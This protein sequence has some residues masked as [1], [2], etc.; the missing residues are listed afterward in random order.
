[1]E[2]TYNQMHER[3]NNFL[4]NNQREK[5]EKAKLKFQQEKQNETG[6]NK[7]D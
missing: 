2:Q 4:I 3:I 1:M 6:F 7:K 5:I